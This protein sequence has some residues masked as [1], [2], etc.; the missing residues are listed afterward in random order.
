MLNLGILSEEDKE[1]IRPR[2]LKSFVDSSLGK[3]VRSSKDVRREW[4]FRL[5]DGELIVQGIID[6]C[7]V[8]NGQWVLV[9][10]KTD[11]CAA[12]E[13]PG[14]YGE[15]IRWYARALREITEYPVAEC[16]LYGLYEGAAVPVS[17]M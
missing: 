10:Y 15:Q 14:K 8:E 5:L 4:G 13:L 1:L 3:R 2:D 9:D 12:A 11:R 17:V 7:F 6:L 16:W